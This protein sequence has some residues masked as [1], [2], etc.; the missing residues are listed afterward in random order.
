MKTCTKCKSA[1][2]LASFSQQLKGR[3]GVTSICKT[4]TSERGKKWH[5]ENRDKSIAT[6]A[7]YNASN[8]EAHRAYCIAWRSENKIRLAKVSADWARNNVGKKAASSAKRRAAKLRAIPLWASLSDIKKYYVLAASLT[9]TTGV[10]AN[11]DHIVPLQSSIVCGL[12]CPANL[13]ILQEW[14]NKS[15]GNYYWPDM[16]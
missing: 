16:P 13:T 10:K 1:K 12:H 2:E 5:L 6:K 9:K 8:K 11:V 3:F 14:K 15:K 7:I 4:C